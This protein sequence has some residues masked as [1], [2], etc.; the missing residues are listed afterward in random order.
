M[1]F[2]HKGNNLVESKETTDGVYDDVD[3]KQQENGT[4]ISQFKYI[5]FVTRSCQH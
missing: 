2:I 1:C 4:N 3:G 5:Q